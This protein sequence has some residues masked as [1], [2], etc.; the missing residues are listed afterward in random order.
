MSAFSLPTEATHVNPLWPLDF[1]VR[2]I[3]GSSV[4]TRMFFGVRFPPRTRTD[5]SLWDLTTLAFRRPLKEVVA[6]EQEI[7]EMGTGP[8]ALLSIYL[9]KHRRIT[10]VTSVDIEPENLSSAAEA[11]RLNGVELQLVQSDLFSALRGRWDI[12]FFNPPYVPTHHLLYPPT[13][14]KRPLASDGGEEGVDVIARF[15]DQVRRHTD[16]NSRILVGIN[17][18]FVSEETLERMGERFGFVISRKFDPTL[19]PSKVY[20]FVRRDTR[21]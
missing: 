18:I 19:W 20:E 12:V 10:R 1:F 6:N 7:L 14:K 21:A 15:L 9:C 11:A 4:L 2:L 5:A 16:E 13:G 8:L 17:T 3:S